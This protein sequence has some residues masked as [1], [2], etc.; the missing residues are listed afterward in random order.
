MKK[1]VM[2]LLLMLPMV[3]NAGGF[4]ICVNGVDMSTG[5]RCDGNGIGN[6][7]PMQF[8]PKGREALEVILNSR[9]YMASGVDQS[10]WSH[11]VGVYNGNQFPRIR[12]LV[13]NC[14]V[15]PNA[16]QFECVSWPK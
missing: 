1:F 12:N 7:G 8:Y 4:S 9:P 3:A 13:F 11:Y 2:M 14:K 5:K 15:S 16:Q 10:G 6:S